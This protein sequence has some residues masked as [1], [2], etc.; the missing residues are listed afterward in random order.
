MH[1][2]KFIAT[3]FIV[4]VTLAIAGVFEKMQPPV[5]RVVL[6]PGHGGIGSTNIERFG[7]R[8]D[9][10]SKAYL[11]P[12]AEGASH[13]GLWEH[14]LVYE[15]AL[16]AKSLLDY[17]AP[18]GDFSKFREIL[19]R[20]CD[21]E[22]QQ[23]LI[24]TSLSRG[25]SRNREDISGRNDPNA[26]FRLY[27]FPGVDGTILPARISRINAKKPHLVVCL[28][29]TRD[30]SATYRGL[31]PVIVAPHSI[32]H[33]GLLYLQGKIKNKDFFFKSPYT[34]WFQESNKKNSF[35]WFLNDAASYFTGYQL[36][37]SG[38]LDL[39]SF[40][41]YRYNMVT[42]AYRDNQ[43]W[44]EIA[45]SHSPESQYANDLAHFVPIGKFWEREKSEFE[46][47]RREAGEEGFG[48]DNMYATSEIIRYILFSLHLRGEDHP[49]QKITRPYISTWS[50][51]LLVNA[52][53]AFVELGSVANQRHRYLFTQKQNEI[54]EG[55]AVGVYSLLTG[56]TIKKNSFQYAPKG[57]RLLLERYQTGSKMSYFDRAVE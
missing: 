2:M 33:Q 34:D 50:V 8:F 28:H 36:E 5:F 19:S 22:P 12:F 10:L 41:G 11:S 16:K 55:V 43:G 48:G 29:M 18:G 15:I 25:D 42:W 52:V 23:I 56:M 39:K 27:D 30:Y 35:Q 7:D 32:L 54:A 21:G 20:Y 49:H 31:N 26:D 9:L 3:M 46:R 24:E 51:P 4:S 37:R 17:C 13:R 47:Y 1:D 6:D 44:E 14:A 38:K 57:K 53:T 40:K 45:R